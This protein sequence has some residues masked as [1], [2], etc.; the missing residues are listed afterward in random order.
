MVYDQILN[1]GLSTFMRL[2]QAIFLPASR[3]RL[4][5]FPKEEPS[6]SKGYTILQINSH[7]LTD[8]VSQ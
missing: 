8:P 3:S 7:S 1:P 6:S 2:F 5:D 4:N